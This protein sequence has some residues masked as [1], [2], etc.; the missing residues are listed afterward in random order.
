MALAD[1]AAHQALLPAAAA[2][3][4]AA[5]APQ[6]QGREAA[7]VY[8]RAWARAVREWLLL[9]EERKGSLGVPEEGGQTP[10]SQQQPPSSSAGGGG[11]VSGGVSVALDSEGVGDEEGPDPL[12]A[13]AQLMAHLCRLAGR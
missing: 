9:Q 2:S 11:C 3:A 6:P 8:A 1:S 10:P 4:A 7:V 5:G 12:A 13:V